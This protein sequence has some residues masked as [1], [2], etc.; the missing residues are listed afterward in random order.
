MP[1]IP[2]CGNAPADPVD[3]KITTED[4][5][6]KRCP[7]FA[8]QDKAESRRVTERPKDWSTRDVMTKELQVQIDKLES[9]EVVKNNTMTRMNREHERCL[10]ALKT[11]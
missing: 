4:L 5:T 8:A 7:A 6:A 3:I 9:S 11:S 10:G 2:G 1:A